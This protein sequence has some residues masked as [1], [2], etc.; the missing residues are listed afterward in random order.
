MEKM[1]EL[2]LKKINGGG[3]TFWGTIGIAAIVTFIA[4]VLDGFTRPLK[5][6]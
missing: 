2:E 5:C 3:L 4:G 6:N 1:N